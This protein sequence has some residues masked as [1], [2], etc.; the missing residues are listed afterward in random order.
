V[1]EYPAART[2]RFAEYLSLMKGLLLLSPEPFDSG[3]VVQC[4]DASKPCLCS[5]QEF[6]LLGDDASECFTKAQ[7][8]DFL[9]DVRC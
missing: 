2:P 4:L 9:F 1:D 3:A 8:V 7:N 5:R 6:L